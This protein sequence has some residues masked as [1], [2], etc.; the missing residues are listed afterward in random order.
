MNYSP[1]CRYCFPAYIA[2]NRNIEYWIK[3]HPLDI[4]SALQT[5][6]ATRLEQSTRFQSRANIDRLPSTTTTANI[7]II[8]RSSSSV[9]VDVDVVVDSGHLC[10]QC[11]RPRRT[12]A[13]RRPNPDGK[14]ARHAIGIKRQIQPSSTFSRRS[15]T[16][17]SPDCRP[18]RWSTYCASFAA[19]SRCTFAANVRTMARRRFVQPF[20][21]NRSQ[22]QR[23]RR[24]PFDVCARICVAC[25]VR[26]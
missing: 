1:R 11:G 14:P 5:R 2:A 26:D 18:F 9:D 20:S 8:I 10:G 17:R 13:H 24:R 19:Q 4:H 12:V 23:K 22:T 15:T 3:W 16:N 25:T 6:F 7:V 21:R